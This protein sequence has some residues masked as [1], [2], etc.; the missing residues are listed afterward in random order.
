MQKYAEQAPW[1]M[2]QNAFCSATVWSQLP[3]DARRAL[4]QPSDIEKLQVDT[5]TMGIEGWIFMQQSSIK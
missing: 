3:S 5:L 2:A 1:G 4:Q